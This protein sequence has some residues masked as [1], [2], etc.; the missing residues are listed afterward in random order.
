MILADTFEGGT[1][2]EGL[3]SA[4]AGT[5]EGGT[6]LEWLEFALFICFLKSLLELMYKESFE[7]LLASLSESSSML[8]FESS[9]EL[10]SLELTFKNYYSKHT[11]HHWT[12]MNWTSSLMWQML[13]LTP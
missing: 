13:I 4:S 2:L 3:E 6:T 9:L 11:K 5:F 10:T 12:P 7:L 1:T 8:S